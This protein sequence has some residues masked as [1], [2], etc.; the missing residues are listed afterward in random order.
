MRIMVF[1]A[2]LSVSTFFGSAEAALVSGPPV[3]HRVISAKTVAGAI[4]SLK[5]ADAERHLRA[6]VLVM[7]GVGDPLNF[8][9]ASD[10]VIRNEKDEAVPF[11]A[12][13]AGD[14][15]SVDYVIYRYSV[16][17]PRVFEARVITLRT[18]DQ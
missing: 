4:V 2:A 7:T 14:P 3:S 9:L 10:A 15:V 8:L 12:L 1:V 16:R 11:E 18:A 17:K 5:P 13:K 6:E